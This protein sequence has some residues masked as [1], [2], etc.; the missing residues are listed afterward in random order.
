MRLNSALLR[1]AACREKGRRDRRRCR[2]RSREFVVIL[3]KRWSSSAKD[4]VVSLSVRCSRRSLGGAIPGRTGRRSVGVERRHPV[5]RRFVSL[6]ARWM[7][8]MQLLLSVTGERGAASLEL[9][10][11]V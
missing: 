10:S 9:D 4:L 3:C 11:T 5:M 2:P 1:A 8:Q 7:F 6:S